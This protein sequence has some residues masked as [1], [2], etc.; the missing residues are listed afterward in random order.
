MA[1]DNEVTC[2]T[3]ELI[4]SVFRGYKLICAQHGSVDIPEILGGEVSNH[5]EFR[6]VW[7]SPN[8]QGKNWENVARIVADCV[9]QNASHLVVQFDTPDTA[10]LR[11]Q[12]EQSHAREARLL[13][14]LRRSCTCDF[15]S[16]GDKCDA[17]EALSDLGPED[18]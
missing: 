15:H 9:Q 10:S 2:K 4:H 6:A 14:A 16:P 5:K 7:L 13:E 12:L 18:I 17:C 3:C 11:T 8:R 1:Q